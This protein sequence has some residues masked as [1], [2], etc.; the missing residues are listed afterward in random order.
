MS[1]SQRPEDKLLTLREVAAKLGVSPR[2]VYVLPIARTQ[3]SP[4]RTRWAEGDVDA[5]IAAR[6]E[7]SRP[8]APRAVLRSKTMQAADPGLRDAFRRAGVTVLPSRG[9]PD[10]KRAAAAAMPLLEDFLE[11]GN[12]DPRRR[13]PSPPT[14]RRRRRHG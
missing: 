8:G 1:D 4:R 6:R 2:A 14:S 10:P 3:L 7:A 11:R 13:A 9:R 5:F 12:A